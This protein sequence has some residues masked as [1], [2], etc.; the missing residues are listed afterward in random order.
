ML[1]KKKGMSLKDRLFLKSIHINFSVIENELTADVTKEYENIFGRTK[2]SSR[3]KAPFLRANENLTFSFIDDAWKNVP[4][5]YHYDPLALQMIISL[6]EYYNMM[7]D[8]Q[9]MEEE[10]NI[11]EEE[12]QERTSLVFKSSMSSEEVD[13]IYDIKQSAKEKNQERMNI[14]MRRI[15][16]SLEDKNFD[17][18]QELAQELIALRNN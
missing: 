2:F 12:K 4:L 6:T 9:E 14:L 18:A 16:S 11:E 15:D 7:L 5:R 13:I 1:G 10:Y 8:Q 3:I 17:A